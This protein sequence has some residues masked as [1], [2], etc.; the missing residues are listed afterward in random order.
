MFF[1]IYNLSN[2]NV[3]GAKGESLLHKWHHCISGTTACCMNTSMM[4]FVPKEDSKCLHSSLEIFLMIILTHTFSRCEPKHL[5][6]P[7]VEKNQVK[8]VLTTSL[9]FYSITFCNLIVHFVKFFR[10]F[11]TEVITKYNWHALAFHF[12]RWLIIHGTREGKISGG[13]GGFIRFLY[14]MYVTCCRFALFKTFMPCFR[15]F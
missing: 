5:L 7:R 8:S 9:L 1:S 6:V 2:G 12:V 10:S 13:G 11:T 15:W 3:I 4:A 14:F